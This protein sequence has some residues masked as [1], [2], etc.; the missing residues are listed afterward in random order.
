M[1]NRREIS[2]IPSVLVRVVPL[3]AVMLGGSATAA[4]SAGARDGGAPP[5][6]DPMVHS[7]TSDHYVNGRYD[8]TG[9]YIPPHYQAVSK[10]KLHGYF[11]N[12]AESG[13]ARKPN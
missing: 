9:T 2:V 7:Q 3:L 8:K 1:R 5:M 6:V 12:K 4:Y 11:F 10:P 13:N